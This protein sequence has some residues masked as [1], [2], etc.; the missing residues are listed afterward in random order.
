MCFHHALIIEPLAAQLADVLLWVNVNPY[1]R[2]HDC[3]SFEHFPA[4]LARVRRLVAV[5]FEVI[6]QVGLALEAPSA[7]VAHERFWRIV[8]L[9]E[10][11]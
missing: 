4:K 6:L 5:S 8:K 1:V 9:D 3:S 10:I 2:P 11:V 7:H